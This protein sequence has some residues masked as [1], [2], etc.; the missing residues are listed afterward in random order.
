MS[1]RMSDAEWRA[2]AAAG[3][4][5]GKLATVRA[6]GR[7]HVAPVSFTFDGDDIVFTTPENSVKGRALRREP[8]VSL[9]VDDENPP[10]SFVVLEGV[11]TWSHDPDD[12][13]RWATVIGGRYMGSEQADAF[14]R[15][16]AVPG[17]I[18][19]RMRITNVAARANLAD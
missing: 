4:R 19:V 6:D 16:N 3:T 10:Y 15:R 8:R 1:H 18:L 13:L 17:Q 14:G 7:P 12:L 11:V 2:F 9:C 5:T